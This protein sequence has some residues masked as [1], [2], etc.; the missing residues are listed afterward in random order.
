MPERYNETFW[1]QLDRLVNE[2][3]VVIDRPK[4]SPHPRYDDAIYPLDYGYLAGTSSADGSGIDIWLGE[5]G[6]RRVV[7]VICTVDMLKRDSEVKVCLGCSEAEMLT[8]A[9]FVNNTLSMRGLLIRR[10]D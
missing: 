3:K 2:S 8:I 6:E 10:D 4:D 7:G 1:K 5:S 9:K